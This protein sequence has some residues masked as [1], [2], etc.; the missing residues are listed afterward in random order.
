MGKDKDWTKAHSI[1][2]NNT[3]LVIDLDYSAL[4]I[5]G[6]IIQKGSF[7]YFQLVEETKGN[8]LQ[9]SGFNYTYTHDFMPCPD[10]AYFNDTLK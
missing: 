1:I 8:F 10:D 5:P 9:N 3:E 6:G 2:N 4:N 7:F